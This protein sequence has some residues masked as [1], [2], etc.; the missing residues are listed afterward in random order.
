MNYI[1]VFLTCMSCTI[2]SVHEVAFFKTARE[3][4]D[5]RQEYQDWSAQCFSVRN[6]KLL[7]D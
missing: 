5:K 3:C 7:E 4:L 2:P 6:A 1:L